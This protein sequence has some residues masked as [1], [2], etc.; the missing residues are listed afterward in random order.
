MSTLDIDSDNAVSDAQIY[1]AKTEAEEY[2]R[3]LSETLK[4]RKAIEHKHLIADEC[5]I[6]YSV[7]TPAKCVKGYTR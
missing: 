3:G 2:V 6:S 4:N 1:F 7:V 5:E